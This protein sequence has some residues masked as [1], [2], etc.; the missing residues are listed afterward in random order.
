[1]FA[2]STSEATSASSISRQLEVQ[3]F[4]SKY[5]VSYSS[6][7]IFLSHIYLLRVF[8]HVT[9]SFLGIR[10]FYAIPMYHQ[11]GMLFLNMLSVQSLRFNYIDQRGNYFCSMHQIFH[12]DLPMVNL[13]CACAE[14]I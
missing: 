5:V 10:I 1:M 13:I 12:Y 9:M 8:V 7:L 3:H 11:Q 2:L 4:F 6:H 14:K